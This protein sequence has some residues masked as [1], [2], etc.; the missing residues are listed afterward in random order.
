MDEFLTVAQE[1]LSPPWV[2]ALLVVLGSILAAKIVDVIFCRAL[3]TLVGRTQTDVDDQVIGKLHAPLQVTVVLI[4]LHV[5]LQIVD[6]GDGARLV[7]QRLGQTLAV[8]L[9]VGTGFSVCSILL[10]GFAR[11]ADRVTW[12]DSRTVPL[13]DNVAK[14]LLVGGAIYGVFVIW[15]LDLTPWLASAGIAGIAIAFA[16]KDTLGHLLAGLSIIIDAPY[17]V[18]DFIQLGSGERGQVTR[19]GLR[20]TRMLTRDDVEVTIPNAQ[21]GNSTI[22][23]E[24]G[25]PWQKTRVSV[26]VGVAYGSDIAQVRELL[27]RTALSVEYVVHEPEP[28]VRFTLMGDSALIFRVQCWID[29]PVLRGRCIDALNSAIYCALNEAGV[30]IPF[31]QRDVHYRPLPEA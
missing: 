27:M 6:M 16:A 26:E 3:S 20:S 10:G 28:R 21:I 29:E 30:S 25:G 1:F 2:R 7:I 19:I 5:A 17:K 8:F 13:F 14:L 11:L 18:G 23:N 15:G 22:V 4:G 31:P 24:S 9:W 12:V